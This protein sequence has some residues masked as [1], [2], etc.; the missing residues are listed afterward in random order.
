M[1][2]EA[3]SV[4]SPEPV[5]APGELAVLTRDVAWKAWD[6]SCETLASVSGQTVVIWLCEPVESSC[7]A[8]WH[9]AQRVVIGLEVWK[10]SWADMGNVLLLS[11]GEDEQELFVMKQQL[12]GKWDTM[13]VSIKNEQ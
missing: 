2:D 7:K 8:R 12:G 1:G 3:L 13:P 4:W 10:L 11:C 9:V 6:G 5:D